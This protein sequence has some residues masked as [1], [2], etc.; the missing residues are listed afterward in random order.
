VSILPVV[1][2]PL[3]VVVAADVV[4]WAV[5]GVVA[6]WTGHRLAP[7]RLDHDGPVT[8]L[9]PHEVDGRWYERRWRIR[10]WKSRLPEAGG[11]FAGGFS[12]RMLDGRAINHLERFV[13]ETRRAE[14]VHWW[15]LASVPLFGLWNPWW[16]WAAQAAY[17]VAANVPCIAVQRYNRARLLRVVAGARGAPVG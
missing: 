6:G 4:A 5:V 16:L 2:W 3:T 17:A 11:L 1:A 10:R 7:H 8:R 12:K 13:V 14:V 9:R 15:I